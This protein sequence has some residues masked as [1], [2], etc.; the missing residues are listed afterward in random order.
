[1]QCSKNSAPLLA[2]LPI[3]HPPPLIPLQITLLITPTCPLPL[4]HK[5][6]PQNILLACTETVSEIANEI[7]W[8][9]MSMPNRTC[10]RSESQDL[11]MRPC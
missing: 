3:L 4:D 2:D 10:M 5:K 1:M 7:V 9:L 6:P 8:D 11:P